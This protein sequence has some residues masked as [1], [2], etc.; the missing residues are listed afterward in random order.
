MG[1]R[2]SLVVPVVNSTATPHLNADR[3]LHRIPKSVPSMSAVP[4]LAFADRPPNFAP[5]QIL[6]TLS[7]QVATR[8]MAAVETWIGPVVEEEAALPNEQLG[9][10]KAGPTSANARTYLQK[11]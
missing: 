11:T 3:M 6:P 7:I 1:T 8:N 4:S 9:I 10:T 2:K 5:G